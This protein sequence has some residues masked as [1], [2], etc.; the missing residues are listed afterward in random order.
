MNRR[1]VFLDL[2]G[3]LVQPL[4]QERLEELTLIPG[5]AQ[6]ITRLSAAGFV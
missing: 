2:N 3:T 6:A 1:A 5:A 4:K